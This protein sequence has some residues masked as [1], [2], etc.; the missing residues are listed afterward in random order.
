MEGD[1]DYTVELG[2]LENNLTSYEII[3][4]IVPDFDAIEHIKLK[5][6][7]L[8]RGIDVFIKNYEK[9]NEEEEDFISRIFLPLG[10][11]EKYKEDP[12]CGSASSY[13]ARYLIEKYPQYK[14]KSLKIYQASEDGALISVKNENDEIIK[15]SGLV[16]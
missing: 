1:L 12:A 4:S 16:N 7:K 13:I 14:G 3:K 15:V 8:C 2:K 6:G 11:D 10:A 5:T 9:K